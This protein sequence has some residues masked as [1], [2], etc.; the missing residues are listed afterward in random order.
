MTLAAEY[1]WIIVIH[2]LGNALV[3][4]Y[5]KRSEVASM[6]IDFCPNK[7]KSVEHVLTQWGKSISRIGLMH[8]LDNPLIVFV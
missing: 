3:L 6:S 7:V 5:T 1:F 4:A 8:Q 2:T